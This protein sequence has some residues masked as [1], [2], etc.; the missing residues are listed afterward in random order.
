MIV[1][2]LWCPCAPW[3][4]PRLPNILTACHSVQAGASV[5]FGVCACMTAPKSNLAIQRR[6]ERVPRNPYSEMACIYR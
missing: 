2:V 1:V 4:P 5:H 3:S 6:F